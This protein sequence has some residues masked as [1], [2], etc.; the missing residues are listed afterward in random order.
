MLSAQTFKWVADLDQ[1]IN[2]LFLQGFDDLSDCMLGFRFNCFYLSEA[3]VG[4]ICRH[5]PNVAYCEVVLI[6][7]RLS[8]GFALQFD[9]DVFSN[10]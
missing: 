5:E 4:H 8:S 1:L 9:F 7:H 2:I 3:A 6:V 10:S